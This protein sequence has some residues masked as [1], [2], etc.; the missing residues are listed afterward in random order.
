MGGLIRIL[1]PI[2]SYFCVATVITLTA[3]YGYLRNNGTLDDEKMF[4]I[5][6]LLHDIDLNE[7]AAT[8]QTDQQD[9]PSE[10]MSFNDHQRHFRI[11]NL[12]IQAKKD[13]IEKNIARFK[14]LESELNSKFRHIAK[15]EGEV[16]QFLE[17]R[18]KE[19]TESGIVSVREQW[20]NLNAKKQTKI[21]L[22]D[23]I[24]D[25]KMDVVI[26]ILNGLPPKNRTAILKTLDTEEDIKMLYNIEQAMLTG[27][28]EATLLRKKLQ[29]LEQEQN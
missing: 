1:F 16:K 3:G 21:I 26:Q 27:G 15:F 8:H 13:D 6:S 28:P 22:I 23:M 24:K 18:E 9:V 5:V 19:A 4:R 29:E 20:K 7:I 10:E 14:V 2:I 17:E 25:G 11:T 12:H